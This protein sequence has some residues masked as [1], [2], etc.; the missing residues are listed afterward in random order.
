MRP[1]RSI[2]FV[3]IA[4]IAVR[5]AVGA[6]FSYPYDFHSWALIISNFESGNGLY[7]VAGYNYAP[8]WGYM[9]GS[10]SVAAELLGVG[11]LGT[12]PTDFLFLEDSSWTLSAF[13]TSE[14]F[15]IAYEALLT[16]FDLA[17]SYLLYWAVMDRTGDRRRAER[18]FALW[19]LCPFVIAVSCVG[20]MF[21]CLSA[22]LTVLCIV[23]V[24]RERYLLAGSMIG[25][26]SLLKLFP[27]FLVFVLAG[28][29]VCRSR[30][31]RAAVRNVVMAAAG[32]SAAA[33]VL[34]LPQILDGTLPECFAFI[35][36]RAG[37]GFG[38]GT[39]MVESVGVVLI[40]VAILAISL[41]IGIGMARYRGDDVDRRFLLSVSLNV[42]VLFLCPSTPQ[43]VLLLAPFLILLAVLS[44]GRYMRPYLVLC[45]GTTMF[46]CATI[47]PSMMSFSVFTDLL[48]PDVLIPAIEWADGWLSHIL[49][50]GGAV[51]QYAGILLA[52]YTFWDLN[53]RH[54]GRHGTA[55]SGVRRIRHMP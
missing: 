10:F 13:A 18:A 22:L 5:M 42:A 17:M 15:N 53:L 19:F 4:G 14:F 49:Y 51:L 38:S 23:F 16:L 1:S 8:P 43:Y 50:Y 2:L 40:Y 20:G 54:R 12:R 21:D 52:L 7:D 47:V 9:L 29:V 46:A 41:V 35:T 30:D 24:L 11:T 27:A 28:Y 33:V 36:S 26:A 55:P 37:G 48:D 32:A 39:G 25:I 6:L 31:R 45:V 44:D 3:V 34:L